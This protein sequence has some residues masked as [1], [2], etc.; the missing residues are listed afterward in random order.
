MFFSHVFFS[1][2]CDHTVIT[3]SDHIQWSY[4]VIIYSDHTVIIYS[5]HTVII[6]WSYSNHTLIIQWSYSNHTVIIQWS[7]SDHTVIIQWSYSNHTVIIQW[8]YSDHSMIIQW[9][10]S[11]HTVYGSLL[12][13]WRCS[14]TLSSPSA[15][16]SMGHWMSMCVASNFMS[17]SLLS[18]NNRCSM[19]E[20]WSQ[21]PVSSHWSSLNRWHFTYFH[22]YT[23]VV[24]RTW[25]LARVNVIGV[26]LPI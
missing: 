12:Q 19:S 25:Y 7:Y 20:T 17:L 2:Y 8:S 24:T 4:T 13:T 1:S 22:H 11:D 14:T 16:A 18:A 21:S 15:S 23:E 9:S 26:M 6:L 5:D 3:Y 10:Y